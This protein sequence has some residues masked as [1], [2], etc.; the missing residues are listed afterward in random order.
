ME[1]PPCCL[2]TKAAGAVLDDDVEGEER[3]QILA[4]VVKRACRLG[5][6]G[7]GKRAKRGATRAATAA[8]EL[9][10]AVENG[11]DRIET[12]ENL[13]V[14]LAAV[15]RESDTAAQ[16]ALNDELAT[17]DAPEGRERSDHQVTRAVE[18]A[19]YAVAATK[20]T[21]QDGATMATAPAQTDTEGLQP[22]CRLCLRTMGTKVRSRRPRRYPRHSRAP[23]AGRPKPGSFTKLGDGVVPC[24]YY[25]DYI[26]LSPDG[27]RGDQHPQVLPH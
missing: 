24:H 4:I 26:T 7:V 27:G 16:V 22:Q 25:P 21:V 6:Q 17:G 12:I 15:V 10:D 18:G 5:A 14:G 8:S 3:A 19:V 20:D 13:L 9:Q 1:R 23:Q 2:E 11:E